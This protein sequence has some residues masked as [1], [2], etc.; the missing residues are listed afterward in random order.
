[1]AQ[2]ELRPD[3]RRVTSLT[4]SWCV[5][6]GATLKAALA[7]AD[8]Q[9]S[10]M[11]SVEG[12]EQVTPTLLPGPRLVLHLGSSQPPH[13]AAFTAALAVTSL[14]MRRQSCVPCKLPLM[15]SLHQWQQQQAGMQT[16]I[17]QTLKSLLG[18]RRRWMPA[19]CPSSSTSAL[20]CSDTCGRPRL[21]GPTC[22]WGTCWAALAWP[23][24]LHLAR[25]AARHLL[26][27]KRPR[28]A[29][30]SRLPPQAMLCVCAGSCPQSALWQHGTS[31]FQP[32]WDLCDS[33]E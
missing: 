5:D 15:L 4:G 17:T 18:G 11:I 30:Q 19:A 2:T 24:H 3:L 14:P 9:G 28:V 10:G 32:V 20:P 13:P 6:G 27:Q 21:R 29:G 23:R 8:V 31:P 12:L 25:P 33:L 7:D 26:H 1:M 16:S 22:L